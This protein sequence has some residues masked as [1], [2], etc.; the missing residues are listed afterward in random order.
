MSRAE[1]QIY[2]EEVRTSQRI[3]VEMDWHEYWNE[4]VGTQ[5]L[6]S[7]TNKKKRC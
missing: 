4:H 6:R 5:Q 7:K 1:V 2:T 3:Q